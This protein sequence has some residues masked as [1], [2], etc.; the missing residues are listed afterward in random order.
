MTLCSEHLGRDRSS[1]VKP[2]P[3]RCLTR[4][5][6]HTGHLEHWPN[7]PG[8]KLF[9]AEDFRAGTLAGSDAQDR[10]KIS[11]PTC[12]TYASPSAIGSGVD[13]HVV[14]HPP[15]CIGVARVF[16]LPGWLGTRSRC[17][18]PS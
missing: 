10:L 15:I 8:Y 18:G 7:A 4:S 2:R 12:R 11:L 9:M 14:A 13:V 3:A 1:S 17:R 16:L 6:H 5:V